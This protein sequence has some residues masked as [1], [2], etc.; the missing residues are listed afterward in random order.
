MN[1]QPPVE[2][3]SDTRVLSLPKM[4]DFECK[5]GRIAGDATPPCGCWPSE[6]KAA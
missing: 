5:H 4:A 3:D 1:A 6:K 2:L